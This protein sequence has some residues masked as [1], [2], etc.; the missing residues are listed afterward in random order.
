MLAL[1][2]SLASPSLTSVASKITHEHHQ[3]HALGILA[4]GASLAR[5]L[6]PT[7]GGVLL[8]NA[9]N[10]MDQHTIYRTFITS[11]A[12]MLLAMLI[13]IY[14]VRLIGARVGVS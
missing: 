12:I 6:G 11:S 3:G 2:N 4:S 7:I 10:H 5:A 14:S 1:G 9:V 13:A 8:N